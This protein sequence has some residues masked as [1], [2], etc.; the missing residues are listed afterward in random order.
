VANTYVLVHGSWHGGWGLTAVARHLAGQ[1]HKV[2]TPTMAG[3]GPDVERAGVTLQDC[4]ASLNHYIEARNLR[5]VI[6]VGHSWGGFVLCGAAPHLASRLQRL[7][8]WNAFVPADGH[9]LLDEVPDNYVG[10]FKHLSSQTSDNTVFLPWE[11]WRGAFMQDGGE[12]AAR[13]A[14]NLLSPEPMGVFEG[15]LDQKAFFQLK[16]PTSYVNCRQDIALPPGEYAW[17]PRFPQRLG[18]PKLVEL[19]GSHEACFTRPTELAE[20]F[21]QASAG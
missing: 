16:I 11:V 15:K 20:A 13:L 4:I 10:L 3:H 19:D 5:D 14:Y 6:L 9:C 21:L 12:E 7:V 18:H 8:F 1:G 17:T 2:Y